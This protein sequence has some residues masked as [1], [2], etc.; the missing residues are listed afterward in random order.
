MGFIIII[1]FAALAGWSIFAIARWLW[2]GKYDE[3]WWQAFGL[4]GAA[5][6]IVGIW[7]AFFLNYQ[8]GQVKLKRFPIPAE[9][10][11]RAKPTDPW[12]PSNMPE[13]IR[14]GAMAT[15]FLSGIALCL[16]PIAVAAFFKEAK[17]ANLINL[18][19]DNAP[20]P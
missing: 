16:A 17:A 6:L 8:V 1:P 19:P 2:R 13:S 9:I 11:M 18:R 20:P 14:I 5:G 4:L 12:Q 7:F 3:K 10:T 15:D